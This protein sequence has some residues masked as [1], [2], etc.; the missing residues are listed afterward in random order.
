MCI[1]QEVLSDFVSLL[2][3]KY[4]LYYKLSFRFPKIWTSLIIFTLVRILQRPIKT[5]SCIPDG[6]LLLFFIFQ[7][8]Y[9][10]IAD[11]QQSLYQVGCFWCLTETVILQGTMLKEKHNSYLHAFQ[12]QTPYQLKSEEHLFIN[13]QEILS[14]EA[15]H[16]H[17]FKQQ[18]LNKWKHTH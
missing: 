8:Q 7:R 6:P 11:G 16:T 18:E 1:I 10:L 15:I 9:H 5:F 14:L 12:Q 13:T 2:F 4:F 17:S 3:R